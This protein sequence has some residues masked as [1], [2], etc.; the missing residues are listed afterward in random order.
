[1][2][3]DKQKTI[4]K[5]HSLNNL[6]AL[7]INTSLKLSTTPITSHFNKNFTSTTVI[8]P[9]LTEDL[10]KPDEYEH[11]S[12]KKNDLKRNKDDSQYIL[13]ITKEVEIN[14]T[15][16]DVEQTNKKNLDVAKDVIS[17]SNDLNEKIS[18]NAYLLS[19]VDTNLIDVGQRNVQNGSKYT[20]IHSL[21]F[22]IDNIDMLTFSGSVDE[23][24]L[25]KNRRIEV[26]YQ[27]FDNT[28]KFRI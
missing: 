8:Q 6:T 9:I 3:T 15:A 17:K 20:N 25:Q 12:F 14:S 26:N 21:Q 4:K 27:N 19:D 18:D 13:E 11:Q 1:M 7:S 2:H 22:I 23:K 24:I 10:E 16:T 28:S 5:A